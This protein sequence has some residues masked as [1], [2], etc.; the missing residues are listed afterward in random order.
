MEKSLNLDYVKLSIKWW[1]AVFIKFTYL[2]WKIAD[3]NVYDTCFTISYPTATAY[4]QRP[5]FFRAEHLATAE[6]EN[7]AY[8]PTLENSILKICGS[9]DVKITLTSVLKVKLSL[10]LLSSLKSFLKEHYHL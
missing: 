9:V 7:C 4:G 1:K 6:G 5:K 8:S 3:Q 10:Y 2:V